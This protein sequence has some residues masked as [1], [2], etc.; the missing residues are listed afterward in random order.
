MNGPNRRR[1]LSGSGGALLG[2]PA[3]SA[4]GGLLPGRRAE[5]AVAPE[6]VRLRPEIE[7]VV[8]WIEE[9]PR[10][11]IFDRAVEELKGG[12]PYREL[13]AALFLAGV[14]NI[15]PRPVG[16]KFHAVLV[17]NSAHQL[18]LDAAP[19]DRLLPF[20][21]ALD[22]FKSSQEQ[23]V[24][25]GDWALGPPPSEASLPRATEAARLFREAMERW[26][27][28]AA[29]AAA[30][31]LARTAGAEAIAGELWAYG[32]RN[33]RNIGHNIIFTAQAFRT[34][35]TIGWQHAEPVL[36]SLVYG[37]LDGARGEA[38]AEPFEPNR[39]L[40]R[41][42]RPDWLDG[43]SPAQAAADL[44]GA[45]REGS[46]R[47]TARAVADA[48]NAGVPPQ[49]VWDGLM[50]RAN[51]LMLQRPG[52]V[53]LHAV[54]ALN[55][56]HYAYRAAGPPE[57]RLLLTLQGAS[58]LAFFRGE[59]GQRGQAAPAD[60]MGIDGLEPE[61]AGGPPTL[62]AV[63]EVVG[64]DP[65]RAARLTLAYAEGGGSAEAFMDLGRALLFRKGTDVHDYKFSAAAFEEFAL[66]DPRWRPRLLATSVFRLKGAGDRDSPL[67]RRAEEA[68][69]RLRA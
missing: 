34:L 26:D 57:T 62:E 44:L 19:R 35:D 45:L 59:M 39:E 46:P 7:P 8:R 16:F 14:R 36:R 28:P 63:Y 41:G 64:A 20:F 53:S 9:T 54:T 4:L 43:S 60:A 56:M 2:G 32:A 13:L 48:L 55:S 49:A 69:D 11:A 52:I 22:N 10:G 61:R 38:S 37:I 42:V 12:L 58:W 18:S 40:A 15:H 17:I 68:L 6:L 66:A 33:Y 25:Q 3:W 1:F 5:A 65:V 29:E 24:R 31:R 67:A 21:W 30:I 50:L 47:E 27:E 51:E 23:D